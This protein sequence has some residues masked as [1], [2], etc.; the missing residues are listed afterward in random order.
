[1]NADLTRVA[2]AFRRGLDSYDHAARAQARIAAHLARL[3]TDAGIVEPARAFEFGCGTGFL[4]RQIAKSIRPGEFLINDLLPESRAH[5]APALDAAGRAWRFLPGPVQEMVLPENLDLIAASS[6]VQWLE[7]LPG[8]LAHLATALRPGGWLALSGFGPDQFRELATLGSA[9]QAPSYA[10][11]A[12]WPAL[13][14]PALRP[15]IC[16]EMR[17]TLAFAD[18]PSLLRHL[19]G[20][21]V[22]AQAGQRWSKGR[23]AAFEAEYRARF[24]R[25]NALPLT[26]HPTFLLAQKT[27]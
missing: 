24:G 15:M 25:C 13:L 1:M 17:L 11:A 4:T 9:A 5:V 23:L 16:E 12:D 8:A 6:T 27:G 2:R 22:N 26:Y 18:A 3:M 14:P 21:G 20:T 19:R 10:H 7:D